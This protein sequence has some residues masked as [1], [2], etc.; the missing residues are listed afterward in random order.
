M[1]NIQDKQKLIFE[2][3]ITNEGGF[4]NNTT[5]NGH[6]YGFA[7]LHDACLLHKS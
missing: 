2:K 5:G 6:Y 1:H 3:V 4:Y 7:G